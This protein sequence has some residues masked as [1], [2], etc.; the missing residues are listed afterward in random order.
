MEIK[1]PKC[2]WKPGIETVWDCENCSFSS[3]LLKNGGECSQCGFRHEYMY[4]IEW[5][6]GCGES[7]PILD[8]FADIDKGLDE[9]N[10]QRL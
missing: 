1:C 4:C 3:D 5:E 9:L 2:D 8:W 7:S 6:G 10:I